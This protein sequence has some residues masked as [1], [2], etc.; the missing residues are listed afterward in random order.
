M[1]P[2]ERLNAHG[3]TDGQAKE[4]SR[5]LPGYQFV[6]DHSW[7]LTAVRVV[8][9]IC[10][11]V[12][13]M[14]KTSPE[15][16]T[17]IEREIT[18]Y[19]GWTSLWSDAGLAPRLIHASPSENFLVAQRLGGELV[20]G[21][22]VEYDPEIYR[23][24]GRMLRSFHDQVSREDTEWT[25]ALKQR[26]TKNLH[27][28]H[29]IPAELCAFIEKC[30]EQWPTEPVTLVP[31]HGDWQPRN[32]LYDDRL[33]A[34]DF[35]R[36]DF[37]PRCEDFTRLTRQ[38]FIRSPAVET[39]FLTGYGFDPREDAVWSRVEAVEAIGTAVWGFAHDDLAFESSAFQRSSGYS[40][41][42]A[43]GSIAA[44]WNPCGFD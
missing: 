19:S 27:A 5:I 22:E 1:R 44:Y 24:A 8:E 3:F 26:A 9:I 40:R 36:F 29:R 12:A 41:V 32:W 20:Q 42:S 15:P 4:L 31:T 23:Q 11:G 14:V 7:N 6:E 16:S 30:V 18:A 37:R 35:G 43:A 38:E 10:D 39:A 34:I 17:H 25:S 28:E 21:S 13:Y 33:M 2:A